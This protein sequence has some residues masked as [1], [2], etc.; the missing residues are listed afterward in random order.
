MRM[1][2]KFKKFFASKCCDK[3]WI[4]DVIFS[5]VDLFKTCNWF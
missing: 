1:W 5:V 4:L 3:I 2:N